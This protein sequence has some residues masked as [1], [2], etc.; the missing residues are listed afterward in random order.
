[1]AS[2]T[3]ALA[4]EMFSKFLGNIRGLCASY[5]GSRKTPLYASPFMNHFKRILSASFAAIGMLA[6]CNCTCAHC[7]A[8]AHAA[9]GEKGASA[10]K[11]GSSCCATGAACCADHAAKKN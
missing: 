4:G 2:P 3:D 5:K 9:T 8:G 10:C 11:T 7:N 1:M 6:L